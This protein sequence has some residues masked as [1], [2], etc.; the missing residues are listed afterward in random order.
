MLSLLPYMIYL[1]QSSHSTTHSLLPYR[2][3]SHMLPYVSR[4]S[5][6]YILCQRRRRTSL[7]LPCLL[8][9]TCLHLSNLPASTFYHSAWQGSYHCPHKL[10]ARLIHT[11]GCPT[12]YPG[13]LSSNRQPCHHLPYRRGVLPAWRPSAWSTWGDR[14]GEHGSCSG[15]KVQGLLQNHLFQVWG[16]GPLL[17]WMPQGQG[18]GPQTP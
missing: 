2:Y 3:L 9:P 1:S 5:L 14:L 15:K 10:T 12:W 16:E 4:Q 8:I 17:L 6:L 11:I 18:W 7:C 13:G